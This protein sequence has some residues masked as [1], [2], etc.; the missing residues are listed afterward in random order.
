MNTK[1]LVA[2]A[3]AAMLLSFSAAASML[4]PANENARD[5]AKGA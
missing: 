4:I 2:V 1:I 3:L 5:N